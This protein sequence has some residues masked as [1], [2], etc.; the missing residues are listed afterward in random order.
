[1]DGIVGARTPVQVESS[2]TFARYL[3]QVGIHK[4]NYHL[5]LKVLET[6][7]KWIVDALF[8]STDPTLLFT[9][10]KP[11]KSLIHKAFQLISMWHPNQMYAKVL[12]AVIG[13]IQYAYYKPDDGFRI[14]SLEI[15]DLNNLGKFLIQEEDQ[16]YELNTL[17]LDILDKIASIGE[18]EKGLSKSQLAKHAY[19]I[20]IAY[21]DNIRK[22]SDVIPQVL[23]VK[24]QREETEVKPSEEFIAFWDSINNN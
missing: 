10:L 17:I 23:L 16:Y 12:L 1:M 14:Y 13:I 18:Y 3:H 7:N 9:T 11:N 2:I 22:L 21:F 4:N 6:N 20:R 19:Q 8:G 24:L 5:F 15:N